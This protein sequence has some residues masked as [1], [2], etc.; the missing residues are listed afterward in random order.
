MVA[1]NSKVCGL[2]PVSSAV[3]HTYKHTLNECDDHPRTQHD[4]A[5]KGWLNHPVIIRI[6]YQYRQSMEDIT[7]MNLDFREKI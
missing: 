5:S 7:G 6:N 3:N 1:E 4:P 2:L